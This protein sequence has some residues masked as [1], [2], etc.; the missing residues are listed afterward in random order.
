MHVRPGTSGAHRQHMLRFRTFPSHLRAEGP[1][2]VLTAPLSYVPV[3]FPSGPRERL[4]RCGKLAISS[5]T[6]SDTLSDR[7]LPEVT[8]GI[9]WNK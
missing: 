7:G 6:K 3:G 8:L 4:L 1:R 2:I 5:T 9:H